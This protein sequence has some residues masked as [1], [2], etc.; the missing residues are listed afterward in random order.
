MPQPY[1]IIIEQVELV[2]EIKKSRFIT[3]LA[4]TNGREQATAFIQ[5]MK[6]MHPNARHHCWAFVAAAP[7][8]SVEL[9][10]SD[11]GEPSG[12]AGKPILAALQGSGLGE[13]TA[14]VVRYSGGIKLG[15]G[16]L[17][18]AYG[19]GVQAALKQIRVIEKVPQALGHI[20]CH[21]P[22]ISWIEILLGQLGGVV[23]TSDYGEMVSLEVSID[24]RN[25][26]ALKRGLK[27]KSQGEL[28]FSLIE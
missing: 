2:E 1:P 24:I 17:V 21:Y 28:K 3:T 20:M 7:S 22:Q 11:D 13:V 19:G 23:V 26:A 10:F 8:N 6:D 16:G 4:H 25:V 5:G 9:G 18:R 14:V 12:T 15:T 27:D